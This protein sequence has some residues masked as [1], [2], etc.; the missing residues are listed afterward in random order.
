MEHLWTTVLDDRGPVK[1]TG[2]RFQGRGNDLKRSTPNKPGG[3]A[4]SSDEVASIGLAEGHGGATLRAILKIGSAGGKPQPDRFTEGSASA[5]FRE[6]G[7]L[8][9]VAANRSSPQREL[10]LYVLPVF[11]RSE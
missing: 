1:R 9:G 6:I 4:P 8:P 5:G 7:T 3:Y 11:A 2:S 10:P